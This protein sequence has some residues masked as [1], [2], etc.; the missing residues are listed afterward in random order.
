MAKYKPSADCFAAAKAASGDKLT[1][2][3]I[4]AA[5]ER[6]HAYRE[7]L[8]AEGDITGMADKLRS[9]AEREAE[10]TKIAAAMQRRHAALNILVRDRL[11]QTIDAYVAAGLKPREAILALM[12]GTQKAVAGGRNSVG[13]LKLAYESKYVG[14]M[15]ATM[16]KERPHIKGMLADPQFDADVV[17]EMVA[18]GEGG[19]PGL[20]GNAD[21]QYAAKLFASYAELARTDLNR[22]GAS[23]GKLDGWAGPQTHDDLKMLSAGKEKWIDAILPRLDIER[24]FPDVE[25]ADEAKAIL[26]DVYDQIVTGVPNKPTA[27]EKGQRVNPANL[28]K[29]LGKSRVLHFRDADAALSYRDEFGYG[30]AI[31]GMMSQLERMGGMAAQMERFGP[32][33]EVMFNAVVDSQRR[34]IKDG[35]LPD[36]VKRKQIEA[37]NSEAGPLRNAFSVMNGMATRPVNVNAAKISG[38]IRATMAMAKLGGAVLTAMP[39]DTVTAALASQFRGSGFFRGFATQVSGILKGRSRGEQGEI[40]HLL[41]EGFDAIKGKVAS[42]YVAHDGAIGKAAKLQ[43][44]FF[45]WSGLSWWTDVSREVAAKTIAAEMGMRS[46][47][48]FDKLPPAYAHV[49]TLNGIDA[50]KW[51]VIRQAELRISAGKTYVTPDRIEAL[52]DE[53]VESLVADQIAAARI[54]AK[55]DAAFEAKRQDLIEDARRNLAMDVRRFVADETNYGVIE[56]DARSRRT[57]TM[58]TRPGTIAGEA[59]R[60]VMQFKGFPVAFTQR[61][62]GR[63]LYGQRGQGWDKFANALPHIGTL[64][65]GLGVAGYASMVMKDLVK[66]YWPPR[67]P[68]DPKT[69]IASLQQGGGL[70]I[71]GDFLFGSANR[72]GS[73]LAETMAGPALGTVSDLL[74][75]PLKARDAMLKGD[76]PQVGADLINFA[77]GNTPFANLAYIKPALDFLILNSIRE[78]VSPGT[79]RRQEK[80]RQQDYG[81]TSFMPRVAF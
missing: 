24:T 4:N 44:T 11:D 31:S 57:T 75:I 2:D 3:E 20:T 21:A 54:A 27:K 61:V 36:E 40:A 15:F 22:L 72:F 29:S 67:D 49:L 58:G 71:Y 23:I 16:E 37:L 56:T 1:E 42:S 41:G 30:T 13:A 64:I 14:G 51:E 17:R 32:N 9:F 80:R 73:G 25:G 81:Q 76:R 6:I 33:P 12:E 78:A 8:K 35:D 10:R 43:E 53:A 5:F 65:A 26:G 70:G 69:W 38:D 18:L 52:P 60:F 68:S 34:K 74:N 46:A 59:L 55:N 62:L 47:V 45:K 19:K 66:G 7:K 50:A 77:M 63:A 79:L 48:A 28:A 39:S